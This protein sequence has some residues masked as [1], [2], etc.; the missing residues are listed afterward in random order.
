MRVR[1]VCNR[2]W[3]RLT[4]SQ[5]NL[6][7]ETAVRSL[8]VQTCSLRYHLQVV[9]SDVINACMF[10]LRELVKQYDIDG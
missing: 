5:V 10:W 7:R 2:N 1:A 9:P 4:W 3:T 6:T 8:A